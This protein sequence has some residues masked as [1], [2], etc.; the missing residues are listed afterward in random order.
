M[1]WRCT[2]RSCTGRLITKDGD[3]LRE[4]EHNLHGPNQPDLI[5]K[6]SMAKIRDTAAS[7]LEPPSRIIN[8]ELQTDQTGDSVGS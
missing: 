4:N 2:D 6:M 7:S 3:V 8:K 5:V 1:Y